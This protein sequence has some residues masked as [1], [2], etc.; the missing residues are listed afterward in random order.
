M[1]IEI[2][3]SAARCIASK[4][5]AHAA[6]GVFEIVGGTAR[7]LDVGAAPLEDVLAAAEN[8]PT[9]AITVRENGRQL[10]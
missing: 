10:A 1:T 7:V 6:E 9:G 4:T 5:C 3:V 8:C 2:E